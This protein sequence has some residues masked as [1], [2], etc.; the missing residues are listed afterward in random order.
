MR[1]VQLKFLVEEVR[2]RE[3][4]SNEE[5][6]EI[7][8][9]IVRLSL[10][11]KRVAKG[12]K[13]GLRDRSEEYVEIIYR[14]LFLHSKFVAKEE[15]RYTYRDYV[16]QKT[17]TV[18]WAKISEIDLLFTLISRIVSLPNHHDKTNIIGESLGLILGLFS[19]NS[20]DI[21]TKLLEYLEINALD[22]ERVT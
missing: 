10:E 21:E 17:E 8:F 2:K 5:P 18:S 22:Y 3:R 4:E 9:E 20:I 16:N 19:K 12:Y 7:I 15:Y 14:L 11:V 1:S 13:I 6:R